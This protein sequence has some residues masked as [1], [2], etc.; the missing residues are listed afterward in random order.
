MMNGDDMLDYGR[1]ERCGG[2]RGECDCWCSSCNQQAEDC[3]CRCHACGQLEC[4]CSTDGFDCA[5]GIVA[6]KR[7][8][9]VA[10]N[11]GLAHEM[12]EAEIR[13]ELIEMGYE[14]IIISQMVE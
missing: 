9:I 3:T 4:E 6:Q 1:C 11:V 8:N 12:A 14:V 10:P 13:E 2:F 5:F 7:T